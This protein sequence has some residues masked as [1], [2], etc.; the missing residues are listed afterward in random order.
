[1]LQLIAAEPGRARVGGEDVHG[2][3]MGARKRPCA[4]EVA[5]AR[6]HRVHERGHLQAGGQ[7]LRQQD[8]AMRFLDVW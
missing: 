8:A 1:M 2:F 7:E 4:H 6:A 3:G 5:K